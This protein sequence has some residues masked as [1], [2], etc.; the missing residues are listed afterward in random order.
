M[1]HATNPI[2]LI[3]TVIIIGSMLL[4]SLLLLGALIS[5]IYFSYKSWKVSR[6]TILPINK[7]KLKVRIAKS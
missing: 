4:L 2:A 5:T 3:I 7:R 6:P 1:E